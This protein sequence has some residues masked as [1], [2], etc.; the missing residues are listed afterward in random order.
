[1][2]VLPVLVYG[3]T[4]SPAAV[5][6]LAVLRAVP[7]LAFGLLAGAFAD[8]R[9]RKKMMVVC[10][11]AAALL[12]ATV[13]AAAILHR[14]ALPQLLVVTLSI[15]TTFVWFDAANFGS[16]P[17]LV[18]RDQVSTALSLIDSS[19]TIALLV[20]PSL[21]GALMAVMRPA[22]A[23]GFD[24]MSYLISAL[25]LAL[26]RRPFSRPEQE[27]CPR[28]QIRHDISEGL[29]YLWRQPVIRT[30]TLSAFC[31]CLSWGGAFGLLVVYASRAL[32]L[33]HMDAQLG[34]LYSAGELGG[35]VAAIVT[36]K[37]IKHLAIERLMT[38]FLAANAIALVL[39][40]LAPSYGWALPLFCCY[41]LVYVI[42]LLTGINAR[43]TLTPD[44]LRS[45]VNTAARLVAYG[46]QPI[47]AVLGGL[48]AE[49]LSIR[50]T[51]SVLALS[52]AAGAFLTG[53]PWRRRTL[54]LLTNEAPQ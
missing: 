33:T 43:Q 6:S 21:A 51:F 16:L 42:V 34:L 12:L 4:D 22:Y 20:G 35:L 48:L 1:M 38:I 5:S 23:L 3:L 41:E 31:A 32:R 2:I 44:H 50:L 46:G 52:I 53:C 8:R 17:T 13:P 24:A 37:L 29:Q 36:P 26:I 19:G 14:L 54:T 27:R 49:W 47:G 9:D 28:L 30:M 18:D 11:S 7:Y 39:L 25:L 45:R 15:G 10:D 40:S